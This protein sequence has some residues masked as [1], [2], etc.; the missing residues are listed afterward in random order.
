M[1]TKNIFSSWTIWFGI[2]QLALAGVGLV[3]GMMDIS[4]AG[5]LAVTGLG[6]IGLRFK[7][8]TALGTGNGQ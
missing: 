4:E 1:Q 3:S 6:T 2:L 7:T 5:T 8:T